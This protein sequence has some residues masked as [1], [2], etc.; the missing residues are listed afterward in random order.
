MTDTLELR[1]TPETR[2]TIDRAKYQQLRA[3]GF[4]RQ[5]A[6][7][8]RR[9]LRGDPGDGLPAMT[10]TMNHVMPGEFFVSCFLLDPNKQ[11]VTFRSFVYPDGTIERLAVTLPS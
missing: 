8:F 7:F 5:L 2:V 4:G 11:R 9:H 10:N 3:E 1:M 6:D